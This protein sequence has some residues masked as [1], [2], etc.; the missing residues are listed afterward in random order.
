M[1]PNAH[2]SAQYNS[3]LDKPITKRS[4]ISRVFD[5]YA[6]PSNL[7]NFK[8]TMLETKCTPWFRI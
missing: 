1:L 7:I 4:E 3:K 2:N 6:C 5:Q 8:L